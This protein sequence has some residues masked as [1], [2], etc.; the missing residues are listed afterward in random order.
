L[1]DCWTRLQRLMISAS[2][3]PRPNEHDDESKATSPVVSPINENIPD[4][5]PTSVIVLPSF[6]VVENVTKRSARA[7][8]NQY[9]NAGPTTEQGFQR[10]GNSSTAPSSRNSLDSPN[11]SATSSYPRKKTAAAPAR[12]EDPSQALAKL[13]FQ[14]PVAPFPGQE[15]NSH[16]YPHDFLI[17]ICSHR[18]RDARCGISAPILKKEFEKQ[19]RPLGL[20]RDLT[21]SREGGA[22]VVFVN[23]V[24]GHKYAANVIIYR[25][26]DGQGI[27]LGRVTPQ[28]VH[29]IVKHTVLEGKLVDKTML[30][31][32]FNRKEGLVSW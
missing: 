26:S 15:L 11:S 24:G 12:Q 27:W 30:R 31:G 23:H 28:H 21:D 16:P 32:G 19:L 10:S 6:A 8:I 29:G 18:H 13:N 20:W 22:S 1:T 9:I 4:A 7:L 3:L 2:N 5:P 25:K 14:E 17:L